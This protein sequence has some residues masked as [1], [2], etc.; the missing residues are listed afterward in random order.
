MIRA[1]SHCVLELACD[2][3]ADWRSALSC[4]QWSIAINLSAL[5]FAEGDLLVRLLSTIRLRGIP[6]NASPSN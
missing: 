3:I 4:P 5:D 1:I 6:P 2:Q